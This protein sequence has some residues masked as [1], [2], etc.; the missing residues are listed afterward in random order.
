MA[1]RGYFTHRPQIEGQEISF[2]LISGSAEAQKNNSAAAL[3]WYEKVIASI[4]AIRRFIKISLM[5]ILKIKILTR[6]YFMMK[7]LRIKSARFGV[8]ARAR[9][10]I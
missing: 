8:A 7:R 9:N 4:R 10:F 1:E 5:S 3:A 6:R 2:Y